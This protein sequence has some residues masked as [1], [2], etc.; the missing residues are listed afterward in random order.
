MSEAERKEL[1]THVA[2]FKALA[3]PSRLKTISLLA[4]HEELCACEL[5]AALDQGQSLTSYHL[6]ILE[7]CGLVERREVGTWSH[8]RLNSDRFSEFLSAQCCMSLLNQ[9]GMICT[10]KRGR[11]PR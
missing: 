1:N 9:E 4:Q 5:E 6:A 3:S 11:C 2:L 7:R 10:E 8:Y